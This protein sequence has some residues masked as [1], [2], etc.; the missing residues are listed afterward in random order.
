M[1]PMQAR[2]AALY[3]HAADK[4]RETAMSL[5]IAENLAEHIG[6]AIADGLAEDFGGEVLSFPKDSAYM[7]SQRER[8]ILDAREKG[9]SLIELMRTYKMTERGL[10]KLI[11]RATTRRAESTE[12]LLIF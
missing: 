9:T 6:A 2:R 7:L 3:A 4:A 11:T 10:R 1:K 8:E 5:G 12:Q